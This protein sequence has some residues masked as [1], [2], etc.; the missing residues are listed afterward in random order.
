[1]VTPAAEWA[2]GQA[3]ARDAFLR[4]L[5]E[6]LRTDHR[7]AAAWLIGG[8]GRADPQAD[9][10]SDVNAVAAVAPPHEGALCAR[11]RMT[12]GDTTA[13]R[14]G[15]LRSLGEPVLIHENHHN[16]VPGG[17]MTYAV[18]DSGVELA[19]YLTPL[20]EARLPSPSRLLFDRVGLPP[21][22]GPQA[23]PLEERR[24]RATAAVAFFWMMAGVAARYRLRGWDWQVNRVL[25]ML[26]AQID[27]VR[28]LVAG[29]PPRF[30][31]PPPSSVA[32]TPAA[33][34]AAI[35]GLC[36]EM[37][38]LAPA[39]VRLGGGVPPAAARGL[40]ERRLVPALHGQ[41]VGEPRL[42]GTLAYIGDHLPERLALADLARA[43][44]LSPAHFSTVFRRST[45][46]PPL[47]YVQRVRL[48]RAKELLA[49]GALS[50][51]E[52]ARAVGFRD[53]AYF[54]RAFTRATG[55]TPGRYRARG[56]SGWHLGDV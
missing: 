33:Q 2:A 15:L 16:A 39:V 5:A 14:L 55:E 54:H 45:G 53:A 8:L 47:R 44:H 11:P 37:A 3:A 6:L 26:R 35:R 48:E 17:T 49:E 23:E 51:A 29:E 10:L 30:R 18:F 24:A 36:D 19:L 56:R 13:E 41:S 20:A 42:A 12:A 7:F 50:V 4:R 38:A 43:A 46:L 9:A 21:E 31:R 27:D 22:A 1:M 40:V 28:R 52:V 25:D 34:A 32:T